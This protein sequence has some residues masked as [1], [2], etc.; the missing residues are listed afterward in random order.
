MV[1]RAAPLVDATAYLIDLRRG[2]YDLALDAP[3]A[4][5]LAAAF[6]ELAQA[7]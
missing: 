3:A 1:M 6:T 4:T 7:I 5:R 2:H